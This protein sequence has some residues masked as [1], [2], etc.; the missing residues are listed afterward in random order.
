MVIK[1]IQMDN[2]EETFGVLDNL[3]NLRDL[4]EEG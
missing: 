3:Y 4:E 1:A 2:L